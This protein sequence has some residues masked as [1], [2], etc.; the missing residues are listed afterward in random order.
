MT[1]QTELDYDEDN[2][3]STRPASG[4]QGYFDDVW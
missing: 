1:D 2:Q 3:I 4:V